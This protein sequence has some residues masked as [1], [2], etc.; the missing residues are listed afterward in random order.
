M[1]QHGIR[2]ILHPTFWFPSL[3]FYTSLQLEQSYA[4]ANDIVLLAAGANYPMT[5]QSGSGIFLG[6]SGAAA[7]ILSSESTQ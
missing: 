1:L 3:P 6:R 4:L 7:M 5:G 2:H